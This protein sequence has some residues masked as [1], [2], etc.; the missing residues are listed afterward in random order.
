MY[1]TGVISSINAASTD[2]TAAIVGDVIKIGATA[3]NVAF[4][5]IN[6]I[7]FACKP[8]TAN[9]KPQTAQNL[10]QLNAL[11]SSVKSSQDKPLANQR[12]IEALASAVVSAQ[13]ALHREV[14]GASFISGE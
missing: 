5:N 1:D 6:P 4:V 13:A 7:K 10:A 8:Q 11:N 9:R 12:N 2:E 3:A 14:R